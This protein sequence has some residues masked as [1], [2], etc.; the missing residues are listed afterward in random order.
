MNI[1]IYIYIYIYN[2]EEIF[3]DVMI[4]LKFNL[5]KYFI[6]ICAE[7]NECNKKP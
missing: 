4:I 7:R 6:N 2:L 3:T 1:Y 5:Q